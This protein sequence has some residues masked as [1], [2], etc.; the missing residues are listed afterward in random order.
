MRIRLKKYFLLLSLTSVLLFANN[1]NSQ[2]HDFGFQR[3]QNINVS[4]NNNQYFPHPWAGGLNHVQICE[5]DF[6]LDGVMDLLVFDKNGNRVLPFIKNTANN[7]FFYTYAPEYIEK[8][9]DIEQWIQTMDYNNDGKNDLFTYTIGGIKVYRNESNQNEDLQFTEA[10]NGFLYSLQGSIYTNLFVTNVD[11]PAISDI[12]NDG[13]YDILAFWGLGAYLQ[14]HKNKSMELFGHSDS[15]I[16]E[17][18]EN[19]WGYF[20][21]SEQN[22]QITLNISCDN[23]WFEQGQILPKNQYYDKKKHTGSTLLAIDRDNDGDKDLILG[24]IDYCNLIELTNGG[25]SNS[26]YIFSFDTAFPNNTFPVNIVS[27]PVMSW[28]DVDHDGLKDI[29]VSPFDG[30]INTP[31]SENKKCIWFYKNTGNNETPIFQYQQDNWLIENMLDFGSGAYPVAIDYN[32]DGL[33]DIVVGNYGYRDTSYYQYGILQ[34]K[35][36]AQLALLENIGTASNPAFKL[37]SEDWCTISQHELLAIIP[38]F[39][40]L[41]DDGDKD[42][43]LGDANGRIHYFENVA[44]TGQPMQFQLHTLNYQNLNT[45]KFCAPQLLDINRDGLTDLVCGNKN[46]KLK[47]YRNTRTLSNPLFTLI[48]DTL[49]GVDVCDYEISNYG[50]SVPCFFEINGEW[51]LFV[52]SESGK[53][54]YYKNIDNNLNNTFELFDSSII[55]PVDGTRVGACMHNFNADDYIDLI[56][57]NLSGG[58]QFYK[59][60]IPPPIQIKENLISGEM[61][62]FPQPFKDAFFIE[63]KPKNTLSQHITI[64][65]YDMYGKQ[66]L[67]QTSQQTTTKVDASM[68]PKG[69]Y[70][71]KI[72]DEISNITIA[73][74]IIKH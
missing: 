32:N 13:D 22:N 54:F 50:Y 71:C 66:I 17:L 19:C 53:I 8:L 10:T 3:N 37:V 46:G 23:D 24:D 40:D 49:G 68:L 48:T 28:L 26:S 25:N 20:K 67:K 12:D 5:L 33:M 63:K 45:G 47:Y 7:T 34:S 30:K 35:Y 56:I 70:C 59:G 11:Y 65:I 51:R 64:C 16:Y 21:E 2:S 18:D 27:F 1:A 31:V 38:A 62:I 15:L 36:V 55:K 57:G 58:L 69:I 4:D 74:K 39:A 61:H 41:D 29:I 14:Y 44:A 52:G 42:M 72:Y 9:P 43:L 60:V 6:D 73:K